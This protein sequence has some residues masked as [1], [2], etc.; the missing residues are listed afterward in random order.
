[1]MML[2]VGCTNTIER[3]VTKTE[4]VCA[5]KVVTWDSTADTLSPQTMSE[6]LENNEMYEECKLRSE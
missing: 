5:G 4:I 6:I 1:M 3:V 2:L